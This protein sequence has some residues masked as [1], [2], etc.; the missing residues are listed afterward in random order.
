MKRSF[1]DSIDCDAP[2]AKDGE[3]LFFLNV[4]TGVDITIK[5]LADLIANSTK[6]D[7]KILW[8]IEKPDGTPKKQ[9]DIRNLKKLGW[10]A[11]I[12]LREGVGKTVDHFKQ[13]ANKV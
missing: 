8:D 9:L 10:K 5:D 6:F 2:C 4:G 7:G 3:P 11:E 1:A 12:S 13:L